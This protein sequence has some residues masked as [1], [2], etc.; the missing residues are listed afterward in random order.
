MRSLPIAW[1]AV[2]LFSLDLPAED[3][4][5]PHSGARWVPSSASTTNDVRR[6]VPPAGGAIFSHGN[7]DSIPT[8]PREP[9]VA[10]KPSFPMAGDCPAAAKVWIDAL[11]L[12]AK[13]D[14]RIVTPEAKG[15]SKMLY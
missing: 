14:W 10:A 13:D 8:P 9:G 2:L 4:S 3:E 12:R 7:S 5:V 1:L 11:R 6:S 15:I